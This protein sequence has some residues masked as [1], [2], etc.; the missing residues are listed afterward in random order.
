[1]K[2]RTKAHFE[3]AAYIM[4]QI[5]LNVDAGS[6]T[7]IDMNDLHSARIF[8]EPCAFADGTNLVGSNC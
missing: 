5:Y 7:A 8:S 6:I 3:L 2:S 4:L 1:M